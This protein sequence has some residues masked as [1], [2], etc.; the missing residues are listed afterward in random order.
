[1]HASFFFVFVFV[2]VFGF[3]CVC[4]DRALHAQSHELDV[5]VYAEIGM[6]PANYLLSFSRLARVQVATHGN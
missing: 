5:L 6:D 1:M 4:A 2:F 3:F